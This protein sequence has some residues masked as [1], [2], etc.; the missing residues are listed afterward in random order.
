MHSTKRLVHRAAEVY[1]SERKADLFCMWNMHNFTTKT[2][3]TSLQW[4]CHM[5]IADKQAHNGPDAMRCELT[6]S[7]LKRI[8]VL[9]V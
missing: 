1:P 4:V 3:N 6:K 7:S 5:K 2:G 9:G 8:T